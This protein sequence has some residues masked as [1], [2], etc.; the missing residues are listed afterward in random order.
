MQ[1]SSVLVVRRHWVNCCG[2]AA[3][4]ARAGTQCSR[5][6][7]LNQALIVYE[8]GGAPEWSRVVGWWFGR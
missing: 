5:K 2:A 6:V 1:L 3:A 7:G 4:L 8:S